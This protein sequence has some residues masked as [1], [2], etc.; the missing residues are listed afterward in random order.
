MPPKGMFFRNRAKGSQKGGQKGGQKG[1]QQSITNFV[2]ASPSKP[3]AASP[4]PAAAAEEPRPAKR[5]R[6]GNSG[7]VGAAGSPSGEASEQLHEGSQEQQQQQQGEEEGQSLQAAAPSTGA[8]RRPVSTASKTPADRATLQRR[9]LGSGP[10]EAGGSAAAAAAAPIEPYAGGSAPQQ[11]LTPLEQQIVDLKRKH[12]GVMLIVEIGYKAKLFGEDAVV[13]ER[14]WV[15]VQGWSRLAIVRFARGLGGLACGI[16]GRLV[17]QRVSAS[18][19]M[20]PCWCITSLNVLV[21][22]SSALLRCLLITS[23]VRSLATLLPPL[24]RPAFCA[25]IPGRTATS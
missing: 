15:G 5:Q 14:W 16:P 25:P 2:V 6:T 20:Q 10:S 17:G 11:K 1:I 18:R 3:A 22:R 23:P 12:P 13:G 21:T 4:S 24:Q 19:S 9:L 8:P 7:H